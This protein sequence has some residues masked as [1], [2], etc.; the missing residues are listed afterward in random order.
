MT[1]TWVDVAFLLYLAAMN[2]SQTLLIALAVLEM[3]QR[4]AIR[5]PELDTAVLSSANTPPITI[6]APA[7][8]EEANIEDCV[9]AFL[10]VEYPSL[11][12]VVVN[13]GSKDGTMAKLKERFDLAPMD[14]VVRRDLNTKLVRML[15]QSRQDH[16][17]MVVD[18]ENGGKADALNVG[19]NVARTPLVCCVD[20]DSLIDRRALLRMIEPYLYD[21]RAVVAVGGTVLPANG[22]RI[23]DG[24]VEAVGMPRSWLA[25]FQIIEYLRAFIFARTGFNRLGGNLIISGA[26]GLF[27]RE[28]VVTAGGYQASSIGEDAELV[29]RIHR[30]MREK[31][32]RYG[33]V[34]ISDPVCFTEVPETLKVLGKQRD[35][36]QRGLLDTLWRHRA[37]LFRPRYGLIGMVAMPLFLLFEVLGPF[38][39]LAGYGWFARA[40]LFGSVDRTFVILFFLVAFLWGFLLSLQG[41]ILEGLDRPGMRPLAHRLALGLVAAAENFGYRQMTLWFRIRG[42]WKFATGEKSWGD[43]QRRGLRGGATPK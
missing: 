20:A 35:R 24:I 22:S 39:E 21:D 16:R 43:M 31:G 25:R 27:L 33:V 36:W 37:M 13:D 38:V 4:R 19:L 1:V 3:L 28:A 11:S 12:L 42:V 23:R 30:T 26:F 17:L 41:L 2:S 10:Q 15:Y 18:K 8:N 9:R 34:H 32:R 6:I 14:L 29:V 7:Y 5:Q 40:L